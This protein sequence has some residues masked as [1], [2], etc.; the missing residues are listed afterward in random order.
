MELALRQKI[1][2]RTKE[3]LSRPEVKARMSRGQRRRWGSPQA[4]FWKNVYK[5][6]CWEWLGTKTRDGYGVIGVDGKSWLAH[7]LMMRL[8]G[9]EI[10]KGMYVCHHCDNPSCV[11]PDHLF[12]GTP[13]DNVQDSIRKGRRP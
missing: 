4:R 9:V 6:T 10:P 5:G 2:L 8:V 11:N 3:A 1:S 7:R 12:I 13:K